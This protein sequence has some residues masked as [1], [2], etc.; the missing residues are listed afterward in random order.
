MNNDPIVIGVPT[1]LGNIE[2]ADAWRAVQLAVKEINA[3]GGVKIG[4]SRRL[5]A[6]YAID[7]RGAEAGVP[8]YDALMAVERL[9]LEKK[10]HAI[11]VGACR[12]E[13]LLA[14][15]EL[16]ARYKI[17]YL[18][19]IALTPDFEK[20]LNSNY[21]KYRYMFRMS[22]NARDVVTY[23]Q[24]LLDMLAKRHGLNK[25]YIIVQDVLWTKQT[26]QA[27]EGWLNKNGW[28][29]VGFDTYPMGSS[30]FSS[31]LFKAGLGK[32]GLVLS[33]F[34]MPQ[35]FIL[36]RQAKAMKVPALHCGIISPAAPEYAWTASEGAVEGM[37]GLVLETGPLSVNRI[38]K[39]VSFN[40]RY[41]EMWGEDLRKRLSCHG[42][43]VSY[44]AVYVLA[45]AIE[46]AGTLDTCSIISALEKTDMKGAVGRIRFSRDH[47]LIFGI[48]PE[49]AAVGCIFQWKRPGIRIPVYPMSI[50][51]GEIDIPS[52]IESKVPFE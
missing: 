10:P 41:G 22:M 17:P 13:V 9:I 51:E 30:D 6:A 45:D 14:S 8:V 43:G 42:A 35:A 15:M 50:A 5:L 23:F 48:D 3:A 26:G 12:S 1:G 28:S 40:R 37:L 19:T 20:K 2:G 34:D 16:V 52:W 7:T 44:D 4:E 24:D 31:S 18:C 25:A 36:I 33:F 32:A 29:V 21:D 11:L 47:Q 38:L 27:M 49:E 46:R 39:S